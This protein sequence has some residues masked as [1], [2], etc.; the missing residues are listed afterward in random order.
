MGRAP[1][2]EWVWERRRPG[3]AG[4]A[5]K[6]GVRTQGSPASAEVTAPPP[7]LAC[8]PSH[9]NSCLDASPQPNLGPEAP[10]H[11]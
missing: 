7:A 8:L 9:L 4:S 10:T 11:L 3:S 5:P 1:G 2:A 6:P